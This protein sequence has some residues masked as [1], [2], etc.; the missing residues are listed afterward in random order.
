MKTGIGNLN[1]K[2]VQQAE[3]DA[4]RRR[5]AGSE[6]SPRCGWQGNGSRPRR[7]WRTLR[8][9][10]A[11]E[12][13]GLR[14]KI[15]E[16]DERIADAEAKHATEIVSSSTGQVTAIAVQQGQVVQSGAPADGRAC[17]QPP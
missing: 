1:E 13:D 5:L 9:Q 12:I 6:D 7:S 15:S 14:A 3:L 11:N 8:L 17:R 16:V 10:S 4:Q 2:N